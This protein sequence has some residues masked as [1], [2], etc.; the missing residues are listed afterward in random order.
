M[1]SV[2]RVLRP[3]RSVG[4]FAAA[5]SVVASA[6]VAAP[7][8][9][10]NYSTNSKFT[11]AT[12]GSGSGVT[13]QQDY[14][15]SWGSGF[16][17]FQSPSGNSDF[18]RS[19]L[20]V[21]NGQTGARTGGGPVTGS[22]NTAIGVTPT[23][24]AGQVGIGTSF[25]HWNNPISADFRTL[26][27]GIINDTL[28][29]TPTAPGEYG[30]KPSVNAPT[31]NFNFKFLETANAGTNG[32]CEDGQAVPA[33]G[34]EDL[35]GFDIT[36]LNQAFEYADSGADGILGNGDDFVRTYFASVFVLD[37]NG[38][39]FP[40][41]QLVAGECSALGLNAGC[42]GFRTAE[43]AQTTAIFGFAVTTDPLQIPEPASLG[44]VGLALAGVAAARRR[45]A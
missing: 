42:F 15:L 12:F 17:N 43:A 21:G 22:V 2:N 25:T 14:E 27:S 34:C 4:L 9:S 32:R 6:A 40:I 36:T 23:V 33:G 11:S 31:L 18:N 19:A 24:G 45:K 44:L 13:T 5:L 26:Q 41:A 29:L 39:A 1:K 16:G 20:T 38:G 35:F 10:W 8:T 37:P 3:L 28:T 7:I 30:G